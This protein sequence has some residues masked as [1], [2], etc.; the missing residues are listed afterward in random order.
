L[1]G[2]AALL[3]DKAD[4]MSRIVQLFK[5]IS[6]K[7]EQ[8]HKMLDS[9]EY[10]EGERARKFWTRDMRREQADLLAQMLETER[11]AVELTRGIV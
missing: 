11:E 9:G 10:L 2:S 1:N 6:E 5:T 3:P 8:I 7:A 4:S